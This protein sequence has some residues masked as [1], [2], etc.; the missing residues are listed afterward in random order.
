M[1]DYELERLLRTRLV[2]TEAGALFAGRYAPL[3]SIAAKIDLAKALSLISRLDAHDLNQIR[4]IRNEFSHS[5]E[6]LS[7]NKS[8]IVDHVRALHMSASKLLDGELPAKVDYS[9][10]VATLLGILSAHHAGQKRPARLRELNRKEIAEYKRGL[11][12]VFADWLDEPSGRKRKRH[13]K[14]KKK[15][16]ERPSDL[17]NRP[18][19]GCGARLM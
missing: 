18:N 10:T 4:K 3:T 14:D 16:R 2:S 1:L 12:A 13:G 17:L 8:P 6:P 9:F 7:F 11:R 19:E 15:H 5:A